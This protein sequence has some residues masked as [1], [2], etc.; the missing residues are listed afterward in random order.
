MIDKLIDSGFYHEPNTKIRDRTVCYS[1]G[2][3]LF[4]WKIDDN[5]YQVHYERRRDC[6]HIQK[7]I[8]EVY[9]V[10]EIKN[11]GEI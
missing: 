4:D 6:A 3:T 7:I 8:S 1:C 10:L 2:L 11:I 9:C 5:P